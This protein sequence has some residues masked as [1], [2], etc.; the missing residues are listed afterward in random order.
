MASG[1]WSS[2]WFFISLV[3]VQLHLPLTLQVAGIAAV[4]WTQKYWSEKKRIKPFAE[5]L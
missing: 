5:K 4:W 1:R 3:T 2:P